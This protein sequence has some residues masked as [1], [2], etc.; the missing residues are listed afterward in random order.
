M[1]A[2][3]MNVSQTPPS[4]CNCARRAPSKIAEV[5]GHFFAHESGSW[6][7]RQIVAECQLHYF[8]SIF[9]SQNLPQNSFIPYEGVWCSQVALAVF[10]RLDTKICRPIGYDFWHFFKN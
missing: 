3:M 6:E 10:G 8:P 4:F 7:A 5:F 9:F 1:A 2:A